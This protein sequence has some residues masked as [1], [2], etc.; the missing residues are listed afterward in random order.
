MFHQKLVD[1]VSS[2]RSYCYLPQ[3]LHLSSETAAFWYLVEVFLLFIEQYYFLCIYTAQITTHHFQQI[4]Q[5]LIHPRP[6]VNQEQP[7]SRRQGSSRVNW[8][9]LV[10]SDHIWIQYIWWAISRKRKQRLLQSGMELRLWGYCHSANSAGRPA[11]TGI[12]VSS[13]DI[14]ISL[15]YPGFF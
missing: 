14:S 5:E 13:S 15:T 7:G 4:D 9:W 12:Q 10:Y 11:P 2:P 8:S 3:R 6:A 1:I